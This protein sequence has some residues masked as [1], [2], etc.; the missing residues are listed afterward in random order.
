MKT[1]DNNAIF[2][3]T[4]TTPQQSLEFRP[5]VT[6]T[7]AEVL[8][9][10]PPVNS[11]IFRNVRPLWVEGAAADMVKAAGDKLHALYL[12]GVTRVRYDPQEPE[13]FWGAF[14][15]T[16]LVEINAVAA[17]EDEQTAAIAVAIFKASGWYATSLRPTLARAQAAITAFVIETARSLRMLFVQE[18]LS[19]DLA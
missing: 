14:A 16:A 12:D 11:N 19:F 13:V 1:N 17:L 6:G 15:N 8:Q 3:A 7:L 2:L 4:R 18:K 10:R 5:T 9:P